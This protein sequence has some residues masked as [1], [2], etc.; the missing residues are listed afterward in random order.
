MRDVPAFTPGGQVA[1]AV[2]RGKL[3]TDFAVMRSTLRSAMGELFDRRERAAFESQLDDDAFGAPPPD[4]V[5]DSALSAPLDEPTTAAANDLGALL[6]LA[7][8]RFPDRVPN[9]A[10][11]AYAVLDRARAGDACLPQLNLAF[12]L[13]TNTTP[14]DAK[15][16]REFREAERRCPDDP[17]PLWLL[18]QFQS[19]RAVLDESS[20]F[21][22]PVT[23]TEQ[24]RRTFA[25][26]DRLQRRFP[27]S[28]AGWSGAA[29]AHLRL[30]YQLQDSRHF[31]LRSHYRRALALYRR[32]R[33]L[34]PDPAL[35]AGEARAQAGLRLYEEAA[36]SQQ[37][38][39]SGAPRP[40]QLQAR[41]VEYLERARAFGA[42]AEEAGRLAVSPQFPQGPALF[43]EHDAEGGLLDEDGQGALS[44]GSG[45]VLGVQLDVLPNFSGVGG[46]RGR[47]AR[48]LLHP[49]VS[50]GHRG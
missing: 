37:R 13:S 34:D 14:V 18:G 8:A 27:R 16:E 15:T 5:L 12:L 44:L 39:L 45:R 47:R 49:R 25:T 20:A 17:T 10:P 23:A 9:A 41:L 43:A 38:A 46:G 3:L 50:G 19:Q 2:E 24:L 42:A 32:A 30:A 48:R 22:P 21:A 36:R 4:R 35:A 26:F 31:T 6:V 33:A 1:A 11:L 7:A 40:A 28:S 29:D